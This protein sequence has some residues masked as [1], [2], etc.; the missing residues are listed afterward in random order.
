M[1][2]ALAVSIVIVTY[3]SVG[4]IRS[5]LD[6]LDGRDESIEIVVVDNLSRDETVAVLRAEYPAVQVVENTENAGFSRAVNL[7]AAH[8]SGRHLLLL[9]PDAQISAAVVASLASLLDADPTI[10]AVSPLLENEGE[11]VVIVAAGHAPTIPR[12]L[13]HQT[14]LSRLGRRFAAFE[15]HYLFAADL[16]GEPR[17]VDWVSG[18]CLM[19]PLALWRRIG[20]LTDRWFMYAEDVEICLR[21][22]AEGLRVVLDPR[23]HALHAMGGSSSDVDGRVSTAWIVNLFDLYGWRMARSDLQQRLWR[24]VVL[25]GMASRRLVYH[26]SSLRPTRAEASAQQVHRYRIYARALRSAPLTRDREPLRR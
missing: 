4:V 17:D 21:L 11:D 26:L 1:S 16:H 24:A 8:A 3:N 22:R 23:L 9:N 20:G 5:C 18:G 10:G 7:G 12:M 2:G 14:G 6:A 25:A 15:G 13:L 19:V